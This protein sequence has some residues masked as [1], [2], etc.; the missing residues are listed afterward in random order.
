M[1]ERRPCQW[2]AGQKVSECLPPRGQHQVLS[3]QIELE[4]IIA[5]IPC[6]SKSETPHHQ[7]QLTRR[8][9]QTETARP[10][11]VVVVL[12]VDWI[13]KNKAAREET[14]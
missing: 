13:R 14:V 9:L 7:S 4:T 2:T 5:A 11:V 10:D 1:S 6:V 12:E 8:T 3:P